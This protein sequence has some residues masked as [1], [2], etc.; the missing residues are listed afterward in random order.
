MRSWCSPRRRAWAGPARRWP[1]P[2]ARRN[3]DGPS[4][5]GWSVASPA[6]RVPAGGSPC[7]AVGLA[8]TAPTPLVGVD[9]TIGR[10]RMVRFEALAGDFEAELVEPAEGRRVRADKALLRGSVRQIR[11]RPSAE[12]RRSLSVAGQ[13]LTSRGAGP[14]ARNHS[15]PRPSGDSG[16]ARPDRLR[17]HRRPRPHVSWQPRKNREELMAHTMC[18]STKIRTSPPHSVAEG[19]TGRLLEAHV[20]VEGTADAI[21]P[22]SMPGTTR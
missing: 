15:P 1:D 2:F 4:P 19:G 6:A 18:S 3:S 12:L 14:L 21:A 20:L 8:G 11:R 22:P 17:R 13:F 7:R 10:H 9:D 16:R 5:P